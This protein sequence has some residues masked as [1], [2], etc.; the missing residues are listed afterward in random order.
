MFLH[1]FNVLKNTAYGLKNVLK[2]ILYLLYYFQILLDVKL[3]ITTLALGSQPRQGL[4]KVQANRSLGVTF[5]APES[6]GQCEGMNPHTPKWAPTLEI[7][8]LMDFQIFK[9]RLQGS[10]RIRLKSSLY[11]WKILET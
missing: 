8:V 3:P 10:K 7:G 1:Y 9:G 4:T 5:Y 2:G 6:V 11:H